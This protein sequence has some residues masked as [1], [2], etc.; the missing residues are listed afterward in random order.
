MNLITNG[1]LVGMPR[2]DRFIE[3]IRKNMNK[4][5]SA[6]PSNSMNV[7]NLVTMVNNNTNNT[8]NNVINHNNN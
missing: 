5:K 7:T 4:K 3:N 2:K 8:I 1:N 6:I